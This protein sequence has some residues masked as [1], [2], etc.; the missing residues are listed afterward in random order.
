MA[1]RAPFI[2]P[3]ETPTS[4]SQ[5]PAFIDP[6]E[7]SVSPQVSKEI[8]VPQYDPMGAYI[9]E[10]KAAPISREVREFERREG[11]LGYAKE[12]GKGAIAT[13]AGLPAELTVNLPSSIE[14]LGR[15]GLRKVGV[16]VS[17]ET[18][19]PR[20]GYGVPEAS[21]YLFG[22]PKGPV[23]AGLRTTGEMIGLPGLGYGALAATRAAG[24]LA[25]TLTGAKSAEELARAVAAAR[26]TGD[27]LIAKA[28]TAAEKEQAVATKNRLVSEAAIG[29]EEARVAKVP[30]EEERLEAL[31]RQ[32][33]GLVKPEGA[34]ELSIGKDVATELRSS[35]KSGLSRAEA[36]QAEGGA[37]MQKY[38][39]VARQK[40]L[41]SPFG[42]SRLGLELEKEL[43]E[44]AKGGSGP[45]REYGQAQIDLA[46]KA[47]NELFAGDKPVSFKVADNLLR[48]FRQLEAS[49]TAEGA[50]KIARERYKS[51]GDIVEKALENWVGKENYARPIYAEK[52]AAKNLFQ[53][54]LG[55]ALTAAEEVPYVQRG[56]MP[57]TRIGQIEKIV[58]ADRDSIKFAKELMG[59]AQINS[60]GERYA[61]NQLAGKTSKDVSKW[62]SGNESR[63]IDEVPGLREKLTKYGASLARREG[64]A[65]V[66]TQLEKQYAAGREAA[67]KT[68]KTT[69]EATEKLK[70]TLD[71]L[72]IKIS[73]ADPKTLRTEWSKTGGLRKALEDT[74]RFSPSQIDNL[75]KEIIN[76][77]EV[78][79]KSARQARYREIVKNIAIYAGLPALGFKIYHGVSGAP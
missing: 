53:T 78:A 64:D 44:I 72:R 56:L 19:I 16:P 77:G 66:A 60:F 49:K 40:E 22:E 50:T 24:S 35:A 52:S 38:E 32:E 37:A 62:L 74:G 73:D 51:A 61:A 21:K 25:K 68:E 28:T 7:T 41:T 33:S 6:F 58:F 10:T 34:A 47:L 75:A 14:A 30:R 55:Q 11:P 4:V 42:L 26:K 67:K 3:F 63:F 65:A 69:I 70:S 29:K 36:T 15:L 8:T 1:E 23:A 39:N 31:A 71:D 13:A 45:L 79:D 48:E 59:D 43:F 54:K 18:A 12:Y 46:K 20:A 17:E 76:L 57:E 5:K 9:G 2:D 27:E